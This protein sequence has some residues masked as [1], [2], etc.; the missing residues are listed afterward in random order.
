MPEKYMLYPTTVI[1]LCG[2]MKKL[3]MIIRHVG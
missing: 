1:E 3:L 2:E